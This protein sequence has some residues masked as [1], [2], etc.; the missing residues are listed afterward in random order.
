MA[1]WLWLQNHASFFNLTA[2]VLNLS[3][4]VINEL[5]KEA[6]DC[7]RWLQ[8]KVP[9]KPNP[10]EDMP[11]TAL[12]MNRAISFQNFYKIRFTMISGIKNYLNNV[13]SVVFADILVQVLGN[14]YSKLPLNVPIHVPGF[15]HPT[16]GVITVI[17]RSLDYTIPN[18]KGP[19]DTIWSLNPKAQVDDRT[20]FL[21]FSRGL[22]VTEEEVVEL[23]NSKYG[24]CVED[25]HMVPPTS[26]NR[27]LYAKMVVRNVSTIDQIL[28]TC[29]SAKFR[30]NGK[31]VWA[32]KY[33]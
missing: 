20:M 12:A 2:K 31:H 24:D 5:A 14:R 29:S 22:Y 33:E 6:A 32:R 1:M 23:F 26:S 11:Y 3:N 4:M 7:L 25:V 10:L 17:P 9:P 28:S 8:S 13:C 15:P 30:I 21:T 18:K 27:S 19:L 16:F